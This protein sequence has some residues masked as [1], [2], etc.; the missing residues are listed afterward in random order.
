[1]FSYP[2]RS[3]DAFAGATLQGRP[4]K[5][6]KIPKFQ[7]LTDLQAWVSSLVAEENKY[8]DEKMPFAN[9]LIIGAPTTH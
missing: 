1:M 6:N 7:H 9:N 5:E 2:R 8:E 4:W 3:C